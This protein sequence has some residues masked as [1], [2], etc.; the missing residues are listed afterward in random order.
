MHLIFLC[1]NL[2]LGRVSPLRWFGFPHPPPPPPPS[3]P[4][5]TTR[6][7]T[8]TTSPSSSSNRVES[9]TGKALHPSIASRNLELSFKKIFIKVITSIR[10]SEV[11]FSVKIVQVHRLPGSKG[12]RTRDLRGFAPRTIVLH[13]LLKFF[14]SFTFC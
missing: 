5:R 3:S 8:R 6:T 7:R 13:C 1:V 14:L 11:S 4:W 9:H 12:A 2:P 10:Y